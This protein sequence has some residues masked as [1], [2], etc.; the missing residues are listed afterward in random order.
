MADVLPPDDMLPDPDVSLRTPDAPPVIPEQDMAKVVET[1]PP[2][3]V[4]GK[5]QALT[6]AG[7]LAAGFT[8]G[9][10]VKDVIAEAAPIERSVQVTDKAACDA[11]TAAWDASGVRGPELVLRKAPMGQPF[12]FQV[13]GLMAA[14]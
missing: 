12:C 5:L 8:A 6:I 9:S 13:D 14:P 3:K 7:A 11:Y 10:V 2:R 4:L 1:K